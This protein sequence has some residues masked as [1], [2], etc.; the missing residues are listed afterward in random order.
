M[1]GLQWKIL[2]KWM[3]TGITPQF[4]EKSIILHV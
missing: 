4:Q 3:M 2:Y 1:D